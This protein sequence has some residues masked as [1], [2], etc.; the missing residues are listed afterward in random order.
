ME[1]DFLI[2][3]AGIA[4]A[5]AAAAL[6]PLGHVSVFEAEDHPGH[7]AS[8]RSAATY[9]SDYGAP[10]TV[11]LTHASLDALHAMDVLAPL[12]VMVV[13]GTQN[14]AAFEADRTAFGLDEI[15]PREA[16][17]RV[18]ILDPA[19]II[20]AGVTD[21][22]RDLD[23]DLMLQHFIRTARAHG[24]SFHTR[25]RV[26]AITRLPGGWQVHAAGKVFSARHLINAAGAWGDEVARAAGVA[27]L[28]LQP[29]RRSAARLPAPDGHDPSG[30]PLIFGAGET[31]YAK[32]DAGALIV[33]PA[34]AEPVAP[35]DAWADDMVI[36][37]GLA[38]YEAMVT[39]PVT[40]VLAC[41]AGLR[42]YTPDKTLAIGPDQAVPEFLWLVGQG[43]QGFQTACAASRLLADL[44]A[45]RTPELSASVVRALSPERFA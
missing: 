5:S 3:G 45:G 31:W 14:A 9:F 30:W 28:G 10:A 15:S 44:V 11:A 32:R 39:V 36:A 22:A 25:H 6:A 33:S 26:E 19:A 12:G 16:Q 7:H 24:A 2:I 41:W 18:P 20:R 23:T 13:A 38:R 42:S 1:I 43:G 17:A 37:E 34:D 27:P 35:H 21:A 4:G 8:G 29:Y 40:R